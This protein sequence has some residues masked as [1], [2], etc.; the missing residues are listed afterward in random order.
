MFKKIIS[1]LLCMSLIITMGLSLCSCKNSESDEYPVTIGDVTIEKE[2][3]NITVLSDCMA[4]IISYMGYD[5]K[6]VG[7]SIEC[8]QEFLSVVP[9]VGT[10]TQ[11]NVDT[12]IASETHLVVTGEPM[13]EAQ[14][15]ALAEAK[16]PVL[17]LSRANSFE[18][19]KTLYTKL[20]TA[21]GGNVSGKAQGES[22][23]DELVTTMTDFEHAIPNNVVKTA[24]YLYLDENGTLCTFTKG[25]IEHELFNHCAAINILASQETPEVDLETL[26]ISTPTYIFYDDE[27]VLE[28]LTNDSELST[29]SALNNGNAK[30][31]RKVYFSRQ[32]TTYEELVYQMIS[33]MFLQK[34]TPDEATPDEA[35]IVQETTEATQE[36]T[37]GFVSDIEE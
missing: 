10:A 1:L 18:E 37:V 19:L 17:T 35:Q 22:S 25:T 31:V 3:L 34:A 36:T 8:D 14:A 4:D 27:A 7:R 32:G 12:I 11:P 15:A 21:L 13:P 5:V 9:I 20:G 30:Q 28:Y 24:C 2:P 26:K 33:F 16:I 6:M 29:M 23:Y